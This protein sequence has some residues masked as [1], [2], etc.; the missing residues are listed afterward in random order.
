MPMQP[1]LGRRPEGGSGAL[2]SWGAAPCSS[3]SAGDFC[4]GREVILDESTSSVYWDLQ[5][6]CDSIDVRH[7][8][9]LGAECCFPRRVAVVDLQVH[10]GLRA[11]R[12]AGASAK[13]QL[14]A[15]SI[16][17]GGKFSYAHARM[18]SHGISE[19]VHRVAPLVRVHR[20]VDD[21]VQCAVGRQT[22]VIKQMVEVA[23]ITTFAC[24][25]QSLAISPKSTTC[26][27]DVETEA[28]LRRGL[29]SLGS[30][31]GSREGPAIWK[32]IREVD[33]DV[34]LEC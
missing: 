3:Q 20:H 1:V 25:R 16:P 4:R 31:S 7:L 12:W 23:E 27:S 22:A 30:I 34:R 28:L 29:W 26:C 11:L 32:S 21:L 24:D 5:K 19:E 9:R 17:A 13:P 15:N 10:L 2:R 14:V 6:F 8:L 18:M 33:P